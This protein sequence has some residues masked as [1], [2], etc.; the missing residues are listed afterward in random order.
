[1]GCGTGA[2]SSAIIGAA[3]PAEVRGV[4]PAE[5]LVESANALLRG[6]HFAATLGDAEELPFDDGAFDLVVAGF[7]FNHVPR[8]DAAAAECFRVTAR[9]GRLALSVWDEPRN[10]PFFGVIAEA[11]ALAGIDAAE[12]LPPGPDPYRFADEDELRGLLGRAGFGE[13]TVSTVEISVRVVDASELFAG[14]VGGTV[15]TATALEHASEGQ[16]ARVATALAE[17]VAAY[18]SGDG[19]ELPARVKVAAGRR[20]G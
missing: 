2:L 4:D 3:A 17:V 1:V 8:P 5:G 7:V 20:A 18:R 9:G 13:A 12:A 15:R 14:I 10:A 19:I 11:M 16:R 6:A